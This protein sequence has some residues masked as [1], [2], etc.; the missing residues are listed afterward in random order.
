MNESFGTFF[1]Q[2]EVRSDIQTNTLNRGLKLTIDVNSRLLCDRWADRWQALNPPKLTS[3]KRSPPLKVDW[4]GAP[5][6]G[7]TIFSAA[8]MTWE[9]YT[10]QR[11]KGFVS[12]N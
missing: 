3:H 7:C 11:L 4:K 8:N 10:Q 6:Q 9:I 1:L 5:G 12:E 2:L